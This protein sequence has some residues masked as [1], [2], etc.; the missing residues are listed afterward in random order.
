[1]SIDHKGEQT[2]WPRNVR[3]VFHNCIAHYLK[4]VTNRTY[5]LPQCTVATFEV[6]TLFSNERTAI[7]HGREKRHRSVKSNVWEWFPGKESMG[8]IHSSV[9]T[10]CVNGSQ[11]RNACLLACV[12]VYARINLFEKLQYSSFCSSCNSYWRL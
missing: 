8:L 9:I 10:G 11:S 1:M 4:V 7:M 5:W 2:C 3:N 6:L 12:N